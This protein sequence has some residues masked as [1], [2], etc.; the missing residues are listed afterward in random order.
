MHFAVHVVLVLSS[1]RI[2]DRKQKCDPIIDIKT[3]NKKESQILAGLYFKILVL[4][5]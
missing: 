4:A 1:K 5:Y 2:F 3:V